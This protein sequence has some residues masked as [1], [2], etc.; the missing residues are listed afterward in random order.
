MKEYHKQIDSGNKQLVDQSMLIN[1][2]TNK[3][4][5]MVTSRDVDNA[6]ETCPKSYMTKKY[7]SILGIEN[8]FLFQ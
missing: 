6:F 5:N 1:K 8:T 2:Q 4:Q 3:Q 7:L